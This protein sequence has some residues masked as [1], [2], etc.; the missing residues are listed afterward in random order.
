MA[1]IAPHPV[2]AVG[3]LLFDAEGRVLLVRRGRAPGLGLWS[4]PGGAVETG[5][6]LAAAC[7]REVR[8]E[9]GLEVEVEQLIEVVE[10]IERDPAGAL[11][12]HY[13]ILDYAAKL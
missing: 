3:A 5:E 4:V 10:R 6:R 11:L 13:V 12:Y 7:A 1:A 9:T 8:E 2:V